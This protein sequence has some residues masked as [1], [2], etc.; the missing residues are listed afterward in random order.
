[1]VHDRPIARPLDDSVLQLV[2]G[3]PA[4]L[5]RAR[6]FAPEP[7]PVGQPSGKAPVVLAMGGDLKS[8]PALGLG[9]QV[10][11]APHLGDLSQGRLQRQLER[12]VAEIRQP[13]RGNWRRSPV[14]P[15]PAT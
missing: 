2:E 5:R 7:L 3:R 1:M 6:G 8:A 11:L 4:L 10:W 15:T 13:R 12:G 14:M 9:H